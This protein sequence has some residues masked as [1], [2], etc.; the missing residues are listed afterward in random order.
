MPSKALIWA[1]RMMLLVSVVTRKLASHADVISN[2]YTNRGLQMQQVSFVWLFPTYGR[3]AVL[4][5]RRR[6]SLLLLAQRDPSQS[7][8]QSSDCGTL[9]RGTDIW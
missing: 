8:E 7:S 6:S 2:Q 3:I 9:V 1:N 4:M 5:E